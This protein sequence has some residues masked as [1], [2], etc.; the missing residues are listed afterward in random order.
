MKPALFEYHDPS[1]IEEALSLLDQFGDDA[2]ILA[3]G[4]SL[5]PLMNFRLARPAQIIDIN[6]ISS[7]DYV[8]DRNHSLVIG[9]LAR[10]RNIEF[11]EL[12]TRRNPLV[13]EATAHIGHPAIRNRG[14]VCGSLAHADPAAEWP[15][16]AL[17]MDGTFV[18]RN[19]HG[20]R[21]IRAADFFVS[22]F[23]TCLEP[24]EL[25]VEVEVPALPE[26]AGYCFLEIN[27]R[28]GDFAL[29]G[30]AVW[31]TIDAAGLCAD[32]G[33]A[34]LGVAPCAVRARLAEQRLK[35]ERLTDA[36]LA[37]VASGIADEIDPTS[38]LHASAEYRRKVARVIVQR[39][40]RAAADRVPPA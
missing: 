35:G 11:S 8:R 12:V 9:A 38:D 7:L 21:R 36:L 10:Q 26:R 40:L 34:L 29:V 20:E 30:A 16:L 3:G 37:A 28:H 14:T 15:A 33:I 4:Q 25:L 27:R 22:Y 32:C 13:T 31:L 1:T 2:K 17:V 18:A 23:T 39:A 5:V 19:A 24:Q 6:R